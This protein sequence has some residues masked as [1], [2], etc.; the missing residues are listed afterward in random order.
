MNKLN[1]ARLRANDFVEDIF[2][3]EKVPEC[4]WMGHRRI[5]RSLANHPGGTGD[6]ACGGVP[7]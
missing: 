1:A 7:P 4:G 5:D 6:W 3:V 2:F